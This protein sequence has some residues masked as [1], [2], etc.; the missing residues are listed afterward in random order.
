MEMVR[1]KRAPPLFV[2]VT[3]FAAVGVF[4]IALPKVSAGGAS[5]TL[6]PEA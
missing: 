4:R 1:V 5:V 2:R 3:F 6:C